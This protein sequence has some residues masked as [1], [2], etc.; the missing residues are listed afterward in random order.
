MHRRGSF[1]LL[2]CPM[3]LSTALNKENCACELKLFVMSD[4]LSEA[5]FGSLVFPFLKMF[6]FVCEFVLLL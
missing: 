2:L 4:E 6:Y 1:H 5:E 3:T